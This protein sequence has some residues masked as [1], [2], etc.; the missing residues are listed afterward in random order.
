MRNI[1]QLIEHTLLKPDATDKDIKKLVNEAKKYGFYG[2]CINPSRVKSAV[3]YAGGS[4]VKVCSVCG[5]P[6]GAHIF[7]A[8]LLEATTAV[9]EGA[10]EIDMVMDIGLLKEKNYDRILTEIR[11]IKD[12]LRKKILLKVIIE[13]PLLT[14][15]EKVIASGIIMEAG[16]DFVKT[17]TGFYGHTKVSDVKLIKT[18]FP[19][20]KIKAAGGIRTYKKALKVIEA[21]ASRIGTS[22][23]VEIAKEAADRNE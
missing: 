15:K 18:A 8:K 6:L 20:L 14:K 4:E 1:T 16:A 21:G 13:T 19:E 23:G 5:F 22:T 11:I 3:E 10:N 9:E 7:S 12:M 17:A 2:V